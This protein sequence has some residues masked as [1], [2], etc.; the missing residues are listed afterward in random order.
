[1]SSDRREIKVSP[2]LR[3]ARGTNKTEFN[4]SAYGVGG[5]VTGQISL[6]S[7]GV[8][9]SQAVTVKPIAIAGIKFPSVMGAHSAK[10][11]EHASI[12]VD[13][14]AQAPGLSVRLTSQTLDGTATPIAFDN[15]TIQMNSSG[16]AAFGGFALRCVSHNTIV[17][18][19][20]SA[21]F[22]GERETVDTDFTV[23]SARLMALDSSGPMASDV[24]PGGV[25]RTITIHLD[26]GAG[27]TTWFDVSYTGNAR[28]TG[29]A[30]VQIPYGNQAKDFEVTVWPCPG[31]PPCHGHIEI[32]GLRTSI[33]VNP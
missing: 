25:K 26:E 29:P 28:I 1:M 4:V 11:C 23:L 2:S 16:Y 27:P 18:I 17:K 15:S 3:I 21:D 13:S 14:M 31:E 33:G 10:G 20:A 7:G 5:P 8:T 30:R 19:T 24:P 6:T 22:A 12:E 9:K 32:Q